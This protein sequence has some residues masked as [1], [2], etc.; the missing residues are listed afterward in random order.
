MNEIAKMKC[1]FCGKVGK[2]VPTLFHNETKTAIICSECV[3]QCINDFH[4]WIKKEMSYIR[5]V[6]RE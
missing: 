2:D 4:T 6:S 5:G 3:F 1:G